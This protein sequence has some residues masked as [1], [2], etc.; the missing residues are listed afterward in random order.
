MIIIVICYFPVDN[1]KKKHNMCSFLRKL[2]TF[3]KLKKMK[4]KQQKITLLAYLDQFLKS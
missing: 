4:Q 2:R 3:F 1:Y